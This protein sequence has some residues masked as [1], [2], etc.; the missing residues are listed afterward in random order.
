MIVE[1]DFQVLDEATSALDTE[2]EREIQRALADLVRH[3]R[4]SAT[5]L[6]FR[7]KT[8]AP[9]RLLIDCP[10]LSIPTKS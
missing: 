10:Q 1:A 5:M 9:Y 6:I 4:C 3:S 7:P 8:E 2:T